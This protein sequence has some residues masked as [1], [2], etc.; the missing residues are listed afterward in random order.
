[1]DPLQEP[2]KGAAFGTEYGEGDRTNIYSTATTCQIPTWA[3]TD[4][5]EKDG[6]PDVKPAPVTGRM[7]SPN[8]TLGPGFLLSHG[9]SA[10]FA[11]QVSSH[12][13]PST[14]PE[15]PWPWGSPVYSYSAPL[16]LC[17][18]GKYK[19]VACGEGGED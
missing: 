18:H 17:V 19:R 7:E 10:P 12:A 4:D 15:V 8:S 5:S 1:M 16:D 2:F 6:A 14:T 9:Y 11:P 3:P 13:H